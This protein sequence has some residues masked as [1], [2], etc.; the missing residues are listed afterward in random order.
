[1]NNYRN[2]QSFL[3]TYPGIRNILWEK[4]KKKN[5]FVSIMLVDLL[6]LDSNFFYTNSHFSSPFNVLKKEKR[7][8]FCIDNVF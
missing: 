4:R 7:D 1:M 8:N 3:H 2:S 5:I 6:R